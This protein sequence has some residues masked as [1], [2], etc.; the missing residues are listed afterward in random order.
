[1][2]TVT[3]GARKTGGGDAAMTRSACDRAQLR[4]SEWVVLM[5]LVN[6]LAPMSAKEVARAMI[7]PGST[8]SD[9]RNLRARGLAQYEQTDW[10]AEA[11]WSVTAEGRA[12]VREASE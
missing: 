1:M 5:T 2:G 9:L 8:A 6:S 12:L 4:P 10:G 11:V 3:P 7:S